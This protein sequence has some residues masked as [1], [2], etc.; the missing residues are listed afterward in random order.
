[1]VIKQKAVLSS[2]KVSTVLAKAAYQME[3]QNV[4]VPSTELNCTC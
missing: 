2:N 1:M 4:H 3:M